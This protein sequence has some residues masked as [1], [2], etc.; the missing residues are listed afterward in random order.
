MDFTL[1]ESPS[2]V[3]YLDIDC[4]SFQSLYTLFEFTPALQHLTATIAVHNESKIHKISLAPL[5][6]SVQLNLSIPA[7]DDLTLFFKRF[8]KLRKLNVITWSVI[9]PMSY[10]ASWFQLITE[11]LPALI[12]F[13]RESNVILENIAQYMEAFHWPNGWKLEEKNSPNGKN[14]SRI[15]IINTRY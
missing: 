3:E 7:F 1:I 14:Y 6:N 8:P 15:T 13:K 9:E 10:T 11:Y 2:P 12:K 5:L 4:C